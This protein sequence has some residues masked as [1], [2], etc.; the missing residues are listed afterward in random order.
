MGSEMCIRDSLCGSYSMIA[1]EDGNGVWEVGMVRASPVLEMSNITWNLLDNNKTLVKSGQGSDLTNESAGIS[2]SGCVDNDGINELC[3]G[4]SF[5]F[6]PGEGTLSEFESLDD[7]RFYLT[8]NP[9]G[10]PLG[11]SIGLQSYLPTPFWTP[12]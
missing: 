6:H 10:E 11:Y 7:F 12:F 8:Y 2:Y 4:R 5:N 1:S 3:P 9:T